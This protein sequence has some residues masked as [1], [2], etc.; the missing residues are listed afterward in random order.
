VERAVAAGR[1]ERTRRRAA[2]VML[3]L[4]GIFNGQRGRLRIAR[5]YFEAALAIN[6]RLSP[7]SRDVASSL[8]G[9][10]N[11]AAA[12][13]RFPAARRYFERT[14]DIMERLAPDSLAVAGVLN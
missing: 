10:G 9:L 11:I 14:W 1:N 12:E 4:G 3:N 8:S 7:I 2:G 5:R 13:G 6:E